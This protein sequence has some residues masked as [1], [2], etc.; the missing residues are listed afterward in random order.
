MF[1]RYEHNL[2]LSIGKTKE[3]PV[4]Q[5]P[6][7]EDSNNNNNIITTKTKVNVTINRHLDPKC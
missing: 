2:K 7:T 4:K 6:A 1:L 3:K 5:A